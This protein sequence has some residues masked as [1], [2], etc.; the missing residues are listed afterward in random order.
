MFPAEVKGRKKWDNLLV[1]FQYPEDIRWVIYTPIS[2]NRCID[3]LE[4]S[5]R[6]KGHFQMMIGITLYGNSKCRK[7]LTK[8]V[9]NWSLT[10]SQFSIYFGGRLTQQ[11]FKFMIQF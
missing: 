6:P 11:S 4:H 3:N 9:R 1:Y 2:L 7:K 10:L 5:Q 8:Q